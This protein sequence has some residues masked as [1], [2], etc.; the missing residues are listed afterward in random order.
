MPQDTLTRQDTAVD[1]LPQDTA[2]YRHK[3][4]SYLER[5]ILYYDN[6][7]DIADLFLYVLPLAHIS[8]IKDKTSY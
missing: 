7:S 8:I 4:I 1:T 6:H 5:D 3:T 2:L